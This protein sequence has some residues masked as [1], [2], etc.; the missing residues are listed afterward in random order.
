MCNGLCKDSA[1]VEGLRMTEL[2]QM[3]GW[4]NVQR[5]V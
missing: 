3:A 4:A 5:I 2:Q 1:S